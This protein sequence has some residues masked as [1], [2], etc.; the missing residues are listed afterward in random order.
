MTKISANG[1]T[2]KNINSAPQKYSVY[3][4]QKNKKTKKN[5]LSSY[6]LKMADNSDIDIDHGKRGQAA[7]FHS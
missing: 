2:N 6:N 7:R 5:N 1:Q 3:I 4:C